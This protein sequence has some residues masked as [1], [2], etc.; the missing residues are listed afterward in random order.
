M[1]MST[2]GESGDTGSAE[3]TSNTGDESGAADESGDDSG[4]GDGIATPNKGDS[5]DDIDVSGISDE[6]LGDEESGDDD[7]GDDEESDDEGEADDDESSSDDSSDED[8]SGDDDSDESDED[9]SDEDDSEDDESDEDDA[10]E[11][12]DE[13]SQELLEEIDHFNVKEDE[14]YGIKPIK[15]PDE[16]KDNKSVTKLHDSIVE[17]A[18]QAV[19][20]IMGVTQ[21]NMDIQTSK[22]QKANAETTALWR[23]EIDE[24]VK[25]G[26]IPAFEYAEDGK[27]ISRESEG[28]KVIDSVFDFMDKWNADHKDQPKKQIDSFELAHDKWAKAEAKK[29]GSKEAKAK[30]KAKSKKGSMVGGKGGSKNKKSDFDDVPSKG[31]S[32]DD[33]RDGLDI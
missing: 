5:L 16:F 11:S 21:R 24:L 10:D 19:R 22:T 4:A 25:S 28:G 3:D 6:I 15:V 8:E 9:E 7:G 27:T 32:L 14:K 29:S 30:A 18:L 20:N 1:T 33:I 23:G 26:E 2:G 17:N 13:E 31:T 12:G